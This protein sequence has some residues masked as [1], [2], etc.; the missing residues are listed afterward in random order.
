MTPGGSD[1]GRSVESGRSRRPGL[2]RVIPLSIVGVMTAAAA[3]AAVLAVG[4]PESAD[5]AVA[6][7]IASTLN[8]QT[9]DF[10][11][12]GSAGFGTLNVPI[13]GTG[14]MDFTQ[15]AMQLQIGLPVP[16]GSQSVVEKAIYLNK[17][18]YVS[19]SGVVSQLVPGKSWISVDTSQ[20]SGG[21]SITPP[22]GLG[23]GAL[24]G[25]PESALKLLSQGGN[26]ATDL[27]PSTINGQAVEGYSVTIGGAALQQ[28]IAQ[29]KLPSLP[30]SLG[31]LNVGSSLIGGNSHIGYQVFI[32]KATGEL[33]R[34]TTSVVL[35]IIGQT[36]SDD[37][38]MDF[39]HLGSPV[40]ITA[41]PASEVVPYQQYLQQTKSASG[42]SV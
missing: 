36:I 40:D 3:G 41:P 17:M 22:L 2:R 10:T 37:M 12:S 9:A 14:S 19:V 29:T 13:D 39:S 30:S 11:L 4:S 6:S 42:S 20:L 28:K 35:T 33:A 26:Q 15:N 24:P 32:A 8:D 18:I 38:T 34:M 21:T 16:G 5:A 31:S 25:N 1:A 7:A 23:G 27:G